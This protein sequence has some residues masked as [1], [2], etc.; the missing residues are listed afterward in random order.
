MQ[1]SE[2][3]ATKSTQK[4]IQ[5]S[6]KMFDILNSQ[7]AIK[8]YTDE[9][10]AEIEKINRWFFEWEIE[11]EYLVKFRNTIFLGKLFKTSI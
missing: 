9:R 4:Y 2:N 11:L 10:I 1:E 6:A 5:V 8:D 3:D 7:I